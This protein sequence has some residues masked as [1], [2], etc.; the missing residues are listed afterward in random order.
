[1]FEKKVKEEKIHDLNLLITSCMVRYSL[2]LIIE[3]RQLRPFI[4]TNRN[5]WVQGTRPLMIEQV[6]RPRMWFS[7]VFY[8]HTSGLGRLL[9]LISYLGCCVAYLESTRNTLIEQSL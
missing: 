8:I 5:Y 6:K 1:M 7:C 2:V 4:N 9:M 3:A